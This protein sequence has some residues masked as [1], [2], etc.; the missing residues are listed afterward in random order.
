MF[1]ASH[2]TLF[3]LTLR[4][5]SIVGI[6]GLLL[7]GGLNFASAAHGFSAD[8]YKEVD[9]VL[10]TGQLVTA[11]VDNEYSDLFRA[12][13]GG[14]NR[15]GIVV[16]YEVKAIHTGT[17]EDKNW[18]GGTVMVGVY[19]FESYTLTPRHNSGIS[20]EAIRSWTR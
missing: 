14:A 10:V 11:T 8:T 7:G 13:K 3:V 5:G 2:H 18:F 16:R 12:L 15:F 6:G 1:P 19:H 9:V 4:N 17:N 20:H